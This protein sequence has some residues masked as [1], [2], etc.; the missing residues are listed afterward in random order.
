[1]AGIAGGCLAVEPISAGGDS[2]I[3][4]P[5]NII[6]VV[7]FPFPEALTETMSDSVSVIV[8]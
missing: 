5:E 2:V 7:T 8:S 6:D 4:I 3:R 1:L